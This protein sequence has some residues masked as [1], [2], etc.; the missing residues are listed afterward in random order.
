MTK[1]SESVKELGQRL[2][3]ALYE[4]DAVGVYWSDYESNYV[5]RNME[6]TVDA[7]KWIIEVVNI[8]RQLR[9]WYGEKPISL[10]SIKR[11]VC[12]KHTYDKQGK[13]EITRVGGRRNTIYFHYYYFDLDVL[14]SKF[15]EA[16]KESITRLEKETDSLT[17]KL[18]K[19]LE[20]VEKIKELKF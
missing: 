9:P 20:L 13:L 16:R 17:T 12:I 2:F 4:D 11:I 8:F 1:D 10:T 19:K 3:K 5:I 15:E 7:A 6:L 14:Y 18:G